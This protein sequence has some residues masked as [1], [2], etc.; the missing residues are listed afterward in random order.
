MPLAMFND[1]YPG[2]VKRLKQTRLRNR[3]F[4]SWIFTGDHPMDL[5]QFVY[6]W[7]QNMYL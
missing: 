5:N 7:L 1:R 3:V 2:I 6:T 4:H